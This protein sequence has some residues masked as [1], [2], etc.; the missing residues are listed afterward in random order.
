M[1]ELGCTVYE[2]N[3]IYIYIYNWVFIIRRNRRIKYSLIRTPYLYYK[4]CIFA[5]VR[6]IF[7]KDF[8]PIHPYLI[9]ER[10]EIVRACDRHSNETETLRKRVTIFKYMRKWIIQFLCKTQSCGIKYSLVNLIRV[11]KSIN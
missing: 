8:I 7:A 11:T 3:Y 1:Y 6:C 5:K 9:S 2:P 10:E 4:R